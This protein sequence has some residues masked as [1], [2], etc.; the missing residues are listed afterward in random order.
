MFKS[1]RK[2]LTQLEEN[3]GQ[4]KKEEFD[5]RQI[6]KYF[7]FCNDKSSYQSIA[8]RTFEDLDLEE[9]FLLI[10]RTTTRPGQQFLYHTIRS[11]PPDNSQTDKFE[12]VIEWLEQNPDKLTAL[13][14][15]LSVLNHK[16]AYYIPS[17]FLEKHI[18]KPRWFPA[19]QLLSLASVGSA[20]FAFL[21]PQLLIALLLLL[22]VNFGI[23]YWNKSN[24][25]Q[26]SASIPQ[27]LALNSLI[28]RIAGSGYKQEMDPDVL[29]SSLAIDGLGFRMK[30]FKL[31]A[32]LQSEIGQA[33]E[34]LA[35]VIKALFLIEP[36]VL[37]NVLEELESRKAHV[38]KLFEFV[39][40]FDVAISIA[41]LRK[42]LPYYCKP[43]FLESEK[44]IQ[45]SDVY[46]PL[47][48]GAVGN[49]ITLSEKSALLTGSNMSGKTTFI[50]TIGI[51]AII[52]QTLNTCFAKEFVMPRMKVFSAIRI[53]DDLLSEKSYYFEEVL[54]IKKL[55]N[56]SESEF[57][58]L[59]LLDELFKGTNTIERIASGKAVL[60][61]L[62]KS[63]NIVLA[64]THDQ[65][66]ADLLA[67]SFDLFHFTETFQGDQ[68]LFDYKIK[69]GKLLTTNAIRILELNEYPAE[70]TSEAK[71]LAAKLNKLN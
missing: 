24:L 63:E 26:Y 48:F 41:S 6:R 55:L 43:G 58:C 15:D 31:E 4:I 60:S 69:P 28:K 7:A 51:N 49:S 42:T 40:Y 33:V 57:P 56:E 25:Y 39:G 38:R 36:L 27:L 52:G 50:R 20:L 47:I 13:L 35:E 54:T 10:D 23:H 66:L 44:H 16:D 65:E 1:R 8:D 37:F 34:Y 19:I 9:L 67:G 29:K 53:T 32:R 14:P 2:W 21:F 17:L 12:K 46:H 61:Y 64:A 70:L 68:I 62:S 18:Q 5:F 45:G 22:T 11:I 3:H 59:F 71:L 30:I